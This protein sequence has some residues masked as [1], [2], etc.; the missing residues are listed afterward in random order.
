MATFCI[1]TLS[2]GLIE[3][4]LVNHRFHGQ[5]LLMH[6]DQSTNLSSGDDD[7]TILLSNTEVKALIGMLNDYLTYTEGITH[8]VLAAPLVNDAVK[9][10]VDE[11]KLGSPED[12]SEPPTTETQN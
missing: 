8:V 10:T 4:N 5:Q 12:T 1:N 2:G 3:L 9:I 11:S 7:C 6:V